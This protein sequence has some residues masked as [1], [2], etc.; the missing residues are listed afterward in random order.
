MAIDLR[1][2]LCEIAKNM[3]K[4]T[5]EIMNGYRFWKTL[6][7]IAKNYKRTYSYESTNAVHK[8]KKKT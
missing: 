4:I 6:G 7:K 5:L 3:L 1:K 8:K 2:T